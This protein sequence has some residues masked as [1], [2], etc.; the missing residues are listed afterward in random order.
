MKLPVLAISRLFRL[1]R[2][3]SALPATAD[4]GPTHRGIRVERRI[5]IDQVNALGRDAVAEGLE[6]VAVVERLHRASPLT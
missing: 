3:T 5:E 4:I 1:V 6:A 2:G